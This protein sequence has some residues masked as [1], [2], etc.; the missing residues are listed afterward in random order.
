MKLIKDHEALALILNRILI[1]SYVFMFSCQSEQVSII[2]LQNLKPDPME[3]LMQILNEDNL[4]E[5]ELEILK[6]IFKEGGRLKFSSAIRQ[7]RVE[8]HLIL[9]DALLEG[10]TF[11]FWFECLENCQLVGCEKILNLDSP[12]QSLF[13]PHVF[14]GKSFRGIKQFG[15]FRY[16]SPKDAELFSISEISNRWQFKKVSVDVSEKN[17]FDQTSD[18]TSDQNETLDFSEEVAQDFNIHLSTSLEL[19]KFSKICK[20]LPLSSI[21]IQ[22]QN[23]IEDQ[24]LSLIG[25]QQKGGRSQY[26]IQLS[27]DKGLEEIELFENTIFN[28]AFSG[29]IES[30]VRSYAWPSL[31]KE[32]CELELQIQWKK[33]LISVNDAQKKKKNIRQIKKEIKDDIRG[34]RAKEKN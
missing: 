34:Q 20:A 4:K 5:N 6:P 13:L 7:K 12:Y 31:K 8:D 29:C 10:E 23:H 27:I 14:A 17:K 22:I 16:L 18:Q 33:V 3:S 21:N 11:Q 1:L 32:N 19:K 25:D 9:I 2:D 15:K 24:C 26:A 28:E 30:Y